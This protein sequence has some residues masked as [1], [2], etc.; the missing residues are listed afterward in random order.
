MMNRTAKMLAMLGL[1]VCVLAGG[2]VSS[3]AAEP[4][5][6]ALTN[7]A[8]C[9][10]NKE[11]RSESGCMPSSCTCGEDAHCCKDEK[12]SLVVEF[13]NEDGTT[14]SYTVCAKDGKV[15][16]KATLKKVECTFS[17]YSN[18]AVYKGTLDNG[19]TVMTVNCAGRY[20]TTVDIDK[21]AVEGCDLYAVNPD[22]TETRLPVSIGTR[23]AAFTVD[24]SD[25]P[26]LVHMVEQA[27]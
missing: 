4:L 12:S 14:N 18:T 3:F 13:Q 16:G 25:G 11:C 22:G 1:S 17:T 7:N 27:Q 10:K 26:V 5:S 24:M 20:N 15:N 6:V 19:E 2:A 9:C 8:L 21:E 23:R